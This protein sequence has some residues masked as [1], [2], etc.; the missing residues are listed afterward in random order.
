MSAELNA[1]GSTKVIVVDDHEAVRTG[2]ERVLDR[3]P[4]LEPVAG[5][6]DERDV[7]S[8]VTREHVDVA[9]LDYDLERGDGLSLCWRLK[10]RKHAPAI[11]IYSGY[12]GP[13]LAFAA[14]VAQADALVGKADPVETLLTTIRRLATGDR[15]LGPPAPELLEAAAARLPA[16]DLPVMALLAD[17]AGTAGIAHALGVDAREAARRARRVIGRLQAGSARDGALA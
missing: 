9:V 7:I 8:L 17:G 5:L 6:A 12:A 2:L 4:D 15:L 10:Q 14:T 16:E 13:G 3:A 1:T 11:V